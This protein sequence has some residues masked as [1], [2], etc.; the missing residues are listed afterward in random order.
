MDSVGGGLRLPAG[1]FYAAKNGRVIH[2]LVARGYSGGHYVRTEC[3]KELRGAEE[4]TGRVCAQCDSV[5]TKRTGR[6]ID[7]SAPVR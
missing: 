3:G 6:R 7:G 5:H 4:A 2:L 1:R